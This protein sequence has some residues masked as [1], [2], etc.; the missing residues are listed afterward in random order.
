MDNN[1]PLINNIIIKSI[2]RLNVNLEISVFKIW[3]V[4][5]FNKITAHIRNDKL[6]ID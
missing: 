2:D 4:T 5:L 3:A 6:A 1:T